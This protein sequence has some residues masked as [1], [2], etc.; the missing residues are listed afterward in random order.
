MVR[1]QAQAQQVHA[2]ELEVENVLVQ[3]PAAAILYREKACEFL[4]ATISTTRCYIPSSSQV[5]ENTAN[6]RRV[7]RWIESYNISVLRRYDQNHLPRREIS[8]QLDQRV[9]PLNTSSRLSLYS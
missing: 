4:T 1:V 2:L 9:P 7:K 5:Q 8:S 6:T 3:E